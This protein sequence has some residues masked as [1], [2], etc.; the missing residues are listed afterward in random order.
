M[1]PYHPHP[2][3]PHDRARS[4]AIVALI[5]NCVSIPGCCNVLSIPGA[6]LAGLALS[7][8]ERDPAGA[9]NLLRWSWVLYGVG[10]ALTIGTFITLGLNGAFDE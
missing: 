10:L 1:N 5:L 2:R 7:R 8:A 3:E 6:I 4:T 9:R